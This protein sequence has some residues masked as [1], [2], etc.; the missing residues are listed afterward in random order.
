MI[1]Q[2][3]DFRAESDSLYETVM[4]LDDSAFY[5]PSLFKS[6][7]IIDILQHL[8]VWNQ[9]AAMSVQD[10]AK[11]KLFVARMRAEP[12]GLRAFETAWLANL[13][14]RSMLDLWIS[15][16]RDTADLFKTLDPK[17]RLAWT[18]PSMSA[19]SLVAARQMETWA[20]GQAI[21]DLLG[22]ER[23]DSDRIKNIAH[24]GVSTFGW[25]YVVHER[26]PP[27]QTP[28]VKLKAPSGAV[29]EWG[30]HTSPDRVVG[31]AVEFCQVVAQTRNIADTSL[32]IGGEV[33]AEWMSIA[34]CFAGAARTPPPS[35][36]RLRQPARPPGGR[37]G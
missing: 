11:L 27:P 18:G 21:Y 36:V 6:W 17:R 2:A 24:L 3:A 20:H 28:Y 16:A 10:E 5:L 37:A 33:A 19:R 30:D 31:S 22:L 7:T 4:K 34:Q 15:T 32:A 8:H 35:G 29:W 13:A 9:A 12:A 26:T 23:T 25:S 1:N 14:G